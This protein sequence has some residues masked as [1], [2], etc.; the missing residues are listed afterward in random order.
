MN[1]HPSPRCQ[2]GNRILGMGI[3]TIGI[4]I[5]T[6]Q[7]WTLVSQSH[8]VNHYQQKVNAKV[9]CNLSQPILNSTHINKLHGQEKVKAKVL[10]RF[11]TIPFSNSTILR[12]EQI[13][14]TNNKLLKT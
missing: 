1:L 12:T 13:T 11:H 10:G 4:G 7:I 6:K 14:W 8:S 2:N 9:P 3:S 5:S